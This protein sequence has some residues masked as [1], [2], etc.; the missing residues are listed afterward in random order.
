MTKIDEIRKRLVEINELP[1]EVRRWDGDEWPDKRWSVGP[2]NDGR[3]EAVCISPR[4]ADPVPGP[5]AALIAN[6]PSDLTFLLDLWK[7]ADEDG[8]KWLRVAEKAADDKRRMQADIDRLEEEVGELTGL[9]GDRDTEISQACDLVIKATADRCA[10][11]AEGHDH[12]EDDFICCGENCF[13][14]CGENRSTIIA[15]D[16]RREFP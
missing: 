14:C 5:E 9:I 7:Q 10:E 12:A 2:K 3:P 11:I 8:A 13:I 6:A 16:I 1:W 4:Y 15:G